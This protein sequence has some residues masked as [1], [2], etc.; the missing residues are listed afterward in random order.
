MFSVADESEVPRAGRPGVN[1]APIME[2]VKQQPNVWLRLDE[3]VPHSATAY[4]LRR[5]GVEVKLRASDDGWVIFVRY[6]PEA[7]K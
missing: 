4:A 5:Y 1:W 7:G 6:T 3:R 2:A